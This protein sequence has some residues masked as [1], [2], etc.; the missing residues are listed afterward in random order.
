M[1]ARAVETARARGR[2]EHPVSMVTPRGF[3]AVAEATAQSWLRID[4]SSVPGVQTRE[5][6][7]TVSRESWEVALA[8]GAPR[9]RLS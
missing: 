4:R 9:C 3:I 5:R 8:L 7:S 6:T 1:T 2:G